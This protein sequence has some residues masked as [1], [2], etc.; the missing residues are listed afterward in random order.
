MARS[1]KVRSEGNE[2]GEVRQPYIGIPIWVEIRVFAIEDWSLWGSG[3]A[4]RW[5]AVKGHLHKD[6]WLVS[7]ISI[8]QED[9]EGHVDVGG[10]EDFDNLSS[11]FL[12]IGL[13]EFSSWEKG[14]H[15]LQEEVQDHSDKRGNQEETDGWEGNIK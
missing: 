10:A 3:E 8:G 6:L 7:N 11:L 4:S 14:H 13:V 12:G 5:S 1:E 9:H 15:N 2:R